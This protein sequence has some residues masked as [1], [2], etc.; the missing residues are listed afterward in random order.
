[1]GAQRV[2]EYAYV[3]GA[4]CPTDGQ[5]ESLILPWAN[6]EGMSL[7]LEEV[8]RRHPDEHLLMFLD[9]AG[10]HKAAQLKIPKNIELGFLPPYCPELN[11]QEQVWDELREKY[12][13]NRLF[14]SLD[15]VIDVAADGIRAL[16]EQPEKLKSLTHRSWILEPG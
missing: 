11:P 16:E 6:T 5:H 4:V 10:W 8:G 7:F 13:S 1:L 14:K 12:L 9:Q 2:R 3:F 15:A